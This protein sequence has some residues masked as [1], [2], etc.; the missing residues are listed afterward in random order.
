[1]ADPVYL[2]PYIFPHWCSYPTY[3]NGQRK[4]RRR[5]TA[6]HK[7]YPFLSLSDVFIGWEG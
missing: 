2:I 3:Y 6:F 4:E 1:M 7:S 5:K